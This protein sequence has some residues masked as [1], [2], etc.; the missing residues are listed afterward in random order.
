MQQLEQE[1]ESLIAF[2]DLIAGRIEQN[3]EL[4][5]YVTPDELQ[6]YIADFFARNYKGCLLE[7][8]T[9]APLCFRLELTFAAHDRLTEF[10]RMQRLQNPGDLRNRKIVGTLMGEVTAETTVPVRE[11]CVFINHLSPLVRWITSENAEPPAA[12]YRL[13]ALTLRTTELPEGEYVFRIERWS[14]SGLREKQTLAYG[15]GAIAAAD[16]WVGTKAEEFIGRVLHEGAT[17]A[18]P[19]IA[20]ERVLRVLEDL[21]RRMNE[22]SGE[23]IEKFR[24]ENKNLQTIKLTQKRSHFA[25]R[26][27]ADE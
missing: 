16:F 10:T 14:F 1:G 8:E 22:A 2:S 13:I 6:R 9:P 5:R 15:L 17:W 4:G 23:A 24:D 3:R 27:R 25:R 26:R 7:C 19:D 12:F 18:Y 21:K 11:R 20:P